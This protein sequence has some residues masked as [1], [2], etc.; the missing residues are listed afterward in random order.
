[1]RHL[2]IPCPAA[3]GAEELI[4]VRYNGASH[5]HPNRLEGNRI[6]FV[7]HIHRATERYLRAN[8]KPEGFAENTTRYTTLSGA[9]H[10]LVNDL[11]V[12]GLDTKPDHP[13]LFR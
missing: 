11:H 10:E 7:P 8:L 4:L 3:P 2:K 5:P 9:L 1:M 12:T 6:D 13:E